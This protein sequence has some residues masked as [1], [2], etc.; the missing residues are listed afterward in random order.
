MIRGAHGGMS[1]GSLH[2]I[3]IS[4]NVGTVTVVASCGATVS[5]RANVGMSTRIARLDVRKMKG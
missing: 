2:H 1:L 4:S 5:V 3:R